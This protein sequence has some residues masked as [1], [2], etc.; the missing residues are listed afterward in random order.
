MAG[1]PGPLSWVWHCLIPLHGAIYCK[2]PKDITN[3]CIHY[4]AP[5]FIQAFPIDL[6]RDPRVMLRPSKTSDILRHHYWFPRKM[7]SKKQVQKFHTDDVPLP[8][9][10]LSLL[11][12]SIN[13]PRGTT[14]Q[15]RHSDLGR[16]KHYTRLIF[17]LCA[18]E[19][20]TN[21]SYIYP[22]RYLQHKGCWG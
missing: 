3:E 8:R 17:K 19:R 12:G 20:I 10:G 18:L 22:L 9:S 11:I 7:T 13:L 5:V 6:K 14:N 21:N 16:G 1:P 15:E 2:I 4:L